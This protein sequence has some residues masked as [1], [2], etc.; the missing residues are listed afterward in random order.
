MDIVGALC[1]TQATLRAIYPALCALPVLDRRVSFVTT[2]E[3]EDRW[4]ASRPR[5]ARTPTSR[6]IRPPS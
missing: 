4:P 2:Q 6:T 3:L 5:N 1:D